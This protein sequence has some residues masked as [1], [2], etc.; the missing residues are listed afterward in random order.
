LADPSQSNPRIGR[1]NAILFAV[2]D[3]VQ[4]HENKTHDS[5]AILVDLGIGM[6]LHCVAPQGSRYLES[7]G[8][9]GRIQPKRR[10]SLQPCLII[11]SNYD[12]R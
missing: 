7:F 1:I 4:V 3:Q 8:G 10:S 5:D 2:F 12:T 6:V 9:I 11:A